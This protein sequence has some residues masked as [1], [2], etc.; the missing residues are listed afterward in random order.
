MFIFLIYEILFFSPPS[1][2]F[3][4]YPIYSIVLTFKLKKPL[5][6]EMPQFMNI[7]SYSEGSNLKERNKIN[8]SPQNSVFPP[9]TKSKKCPILAFF[10]EEMRHRRK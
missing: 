7:V 5:L 4:H 2:V 9:E 8:P 10:V 6:N 3:S 1:H